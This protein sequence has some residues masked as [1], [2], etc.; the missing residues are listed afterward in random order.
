[1][2]KAGRTLELW[3]GPSFDFFQRHGQRL[4][5]ARVAHVVQAANGKRTRQSGK[6]SGFWFF[7]NDWQRLS[8]VVKIESCTNHLSLCHFMWFPAFDDLRSAQFAPEIG[9][10]WAF[11]KLRP[12]AQWSCG[13]HLQQ[14]AKIC[15][16]FGIP[17]MT[18]TWCDVNYRR[19]CLELNFR[20]NNGGWIILDHHESSFHHPDICFS[21]WLRGLRASHYWKETGWAQRR[22]WSTRGDW[23]RCLP[24]R[25]FHWSM[26]MVCGLQ[27]SELQG[28]R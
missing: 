3:V 8:H 11:Q 26:S 23:G 7:L 20:K 4:R 27:V 1:M 18:V 21:M 17:S 14:G 9:P 13:V 5:V 16:T 22:E 19:R 28:L 25:A 6:R 24:G 15:P 12:L 2:G 10:G